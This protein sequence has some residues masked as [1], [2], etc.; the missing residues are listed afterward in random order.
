MSYNLK[1]GETINLSTLARTVPTMTQAPSAT[2]HG[3]VMAARIRYEL[4][5]KNDLRA[6]ASVLRG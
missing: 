5:T 6:F 3:Q 2:A 1:Q 4:K